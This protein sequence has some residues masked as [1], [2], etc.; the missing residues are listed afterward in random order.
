MPKIKAFKGVHPA[1]A[2][3]AELVLEVENLDLDTAKMI[4]LMHAQTISIFELEDIDDWWTRADASLIAPIIA[5]TSGR[6][7]GASSAWS[8]ARRFT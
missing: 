6:G 3:A 1:G 5:A 4:A 8:P 7:K 2:Y